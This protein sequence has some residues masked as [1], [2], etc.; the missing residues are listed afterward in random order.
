LDKIRALTVEKGFNVTFTMAAEAREYRE[1]MALEKMSP[2]DRE[3]YHFR[4]TDGNG[5]GEE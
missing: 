3:K 4:K 1:T 2:A 5:D